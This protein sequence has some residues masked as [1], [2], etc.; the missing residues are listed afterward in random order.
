MTSFYDEIEIEDMEFDEENQLYHYPCP[1]GDRFEITMDELADNE[2][3]ARCPSCSLIIRVIYD[4]DD[5]AGGDDGETI[6]LAET[7]VV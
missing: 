6:A 2:E 3:I 5:F 1:C 7:V 4:P